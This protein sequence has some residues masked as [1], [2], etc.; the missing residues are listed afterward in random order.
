VAIKKGNALAN[1]IFGTANGDVLFGFAGNDALYGGLGD[2]VLYGGTGND[3]LYGASGK[4][5]G[6]GG[7][8]DDRLF[9]AGDN[10]V[11]FGDAGKDGLFGGAGAD[12]IYGGSGNDSVIGGGGGDMIYGGTG[13]DIL[14]SAPYVGP[15]DAVVHDFLFGG[16]GT[17]TIILSTGTWAEGGTNVDRFSFDAVLNAGAD[18][19]TAGVVADYEPGKDYIVL[20][21]F[22]DLTSVN[23]IVQINAFVPDPTRTGVII[24]GF[25][26]GL[27]NY[28]GPIIGAALLYYN[29]ELIGAVSDHGRAP[30]SVS[31]VL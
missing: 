10:D 20:T 8:G 19:F 4:D 2:D 26:T 25:D 28:T 16:T 29:N 15:S 27:G 13:V 9:G 7:S 21:R 23:D 30:D 11:L 1:K 22:P 24:Y 31:I 6:Y 12:L 17:D 18:R 14:V 5:N 3:V